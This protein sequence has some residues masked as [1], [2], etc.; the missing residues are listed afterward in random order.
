MITTLKLIYTSIILHSHCV[1]VCVCVCLPL[2][3]ATK[4]LGL[5]VTITYLGLTNEA[6]IGLLGQNT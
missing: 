1:C 3:E 6:T 5:F 4:M 2:L